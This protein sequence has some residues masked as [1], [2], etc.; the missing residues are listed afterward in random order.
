MGILIIQWLVV[1]KWARGCK[2]KDVSEGE[3]WQTV[4]LSIFGGGGGGHIDRVNLSHYIY[5]ILFESIIQKL[6]RWRCFLL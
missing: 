2:L 5:Y 4:N 6:T 1:Q 3:P